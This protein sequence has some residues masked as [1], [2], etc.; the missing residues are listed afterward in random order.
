SSSYINKLEDY[1]GVRLIHRTTRKVSLTEEGQ[2]FLP[3]AE[4]VLASVEAA[5][6]SVGVGSAGPTG[7]LRVTAPA[8]FGRLH[9][10]P[11]LKGFM[12]A[13]PDLR[14]DFRFSDAI[15]DM[16]QGGYDI[17]IRDAALKDSTLVA[18]KLAS[19]RRIL[20]ASPD[21]IAKYGEPT[22]PASLSKHECI[23]LSGLETWSFDSPKGPVSIKVKGRFKTDNGDALRD[24]CTAGM[25]ITINSTWSAYQ[26]LKNG[27]LI[28]VLKDYP[29][30]SDTDI[31]AVYPSS[32]LVAPK[33]RAFIDYYLEYFGP[34]PYWDRSIID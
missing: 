6:A 12:D 23:V 13:Y 16:V 15:V 22:T 17:A 30:I 11:G 8:S 14:V 28:E 25:G 33:V 9:L 29:L 31:W 20:C 3:H 19:D 26:Q 18:R 1:L 21:Y 27:D 7:T 32:R 10:L 4:D 2:S 24:S 5:N 34:T